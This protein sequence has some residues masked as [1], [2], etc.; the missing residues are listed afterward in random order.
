MSFSVLASTFANNILPIL[1]IGG[2]GF[3]LGKTLHIEPRSLGRVVFYVFSP[4]LIF[5]L[6][7]QNRLKMDEA[8]GVIALTICVVAIMGL[9]TYLLG[10]LLKLERPV[11]T[12]ILITT[13]FAN[14]GNYGLPL[15]AFAFGEEA[16]SYAGIFFVTTTLLFYTVGVLIASLGH[17]SLK[18]AALGLLK[19]PTLYAVLLA[20]LVNSLGIQ[21]PDPIMRAVELAAG[22]T[23]P[24]MLI[25]LGVELTRVQLTGSVRAMQ[26]SVVLRLLIAPLIALFLAGLFGLNGYARQGSVTEAAMPS[27][28]SATVL[29]T[30]Y[31]LD[32]RLVT[33]IIFI[34][35]LLSPLTLTPLLVFLGK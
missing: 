8:I 33:A 24:L 34:S 21:L 5:D 2:A 27:M 17:M 12:S 26:L 4:V 31:Q 1:L 19:I 6:L 29:A 22:G 9:L 15:V 28:V 23:I 14:T 11:M 25:L 13:M 18:D 32:S 7:L 10:T 3:A 35:T 20:I 16:L 30:E